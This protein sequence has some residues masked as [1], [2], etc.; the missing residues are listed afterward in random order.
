M[1]ESK[2]NIVTVNCTV[3]YMSQCMPMN[4][5]KNSCH[6]MGASYFRWF[7]DGCCECIGRTCINYGIDESRCKTCSLD[8]DGDEDL[9]LTP[10]TES[11]EESLN[12]QAESI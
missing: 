11:A 2:V 4:K 7:H 12:P 9:L 10:D 3:A 6:S 1:D 5:C 8:E